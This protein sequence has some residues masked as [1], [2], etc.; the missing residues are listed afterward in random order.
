MMQF[1]ILQADCE[2]CL[3]ENV[4]N[5]HDLVYFIGSVQY[6]STTAIQ[7]PESALYNAESALDFAKNLDVCPDIMH[8]YI[9]CSSFD[10]YCCHDR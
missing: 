10:E 8:F 5:Y 2:F 9:I 7:T 1:S 6:R 4:A 3:V